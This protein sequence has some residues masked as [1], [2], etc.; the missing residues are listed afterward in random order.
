MRVLL[1]LLLSAVSL[2]AQTTINGSRRVLGETNITTSRIS[3]EYANDGTTG[4]TVNL[5][6]KRTAANAAVLAGTGDTTKMIGVVT[7]GAGTTGNAVICVLG[8]CPVVADNTTTIGDYAIIGTGTAGR[9]RSAGTTRPGSGQILGV[10]TQSCSAAAACEVD[11]TIGAQGSGTPDAHAATHLSNGS[12]PMAAAS[13][14]VRGTVTTSTSTS[15]VVST[16]DTSVTNARTPTSIPDLLSMAGS[17]LT[18]N[19]AAPASPAAGYLKLFGDSTDLRFHDKNSAGTI[20]TTV[21]AD[22]GTSNQWFSAMSAAGVFTKSQPAF[23]NLSG[24]ATLAQLPAPANIAPCEIHLGDAGAASSV[25]AD[26]ND[27]LRAC[28]N[29]FGTTLTISE[30]KCWA[31][32]GSPTVTPII[33]GGSATSILTG[34]CTCDQTEGGAT[35]SVQSTPPTQTANQLIDGNITTAGGAAKLVVIYITR[36]K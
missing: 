29:V 34:A 33:T 8:R 19:I 11:F 2:L 15:S 21:V 4:T 17:I 9:V 10:F 32:T 14:T 3:V 25:L 1:V 27:G 5:L 7:S 24:A 36:T 35:C 28:K 12:D 22:A 16:D 18:T 23:S 6:A 13:A 20:G 26:D 31:N 30:V